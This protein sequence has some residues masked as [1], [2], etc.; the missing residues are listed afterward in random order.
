MSLGILLG[1]VGS[2]SGG[3]WQGHSAILSNNGVASQPQRIPMLWKVT[4][5]CAALLGRFGLLFGG[6]GWLLAT[7]GAVFGRSWELLDPLG[8]S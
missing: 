2:L 1:A 8:G 3:C 7:L 5:A 4:G 6:L